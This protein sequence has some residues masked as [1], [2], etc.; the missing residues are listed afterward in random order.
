MK[1]ILIIVKKYPEMH[2]DFHSHNDYDLSV[3]NVIEGLKA[4]CHGLHL[5]VNGMGER[6]GNAPLAS[7]VAV[8]NDFLPDIKINIKEDALHKVSQIVATFTG[9]RIPAGFPISSPGDFKAVED[10]SNL[11]KNA[12]YFLR[13]FLIHLI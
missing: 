9:F 7:V 11:I 13:V 2:F 4:G 8:I 10:I 3:S 6:A 12:L 5:T 1:E